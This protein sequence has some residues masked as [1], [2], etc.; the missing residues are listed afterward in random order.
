MEICAHQMTI[1]NFSFILLAR[2]MK[3]KNKC[4]K[5]KKSGPFLQPLFS[6]SYL[7]V[8]KVISE[9]NRGERKLRLS[10]ERFRCSWVTA[11]FEAWLAADQSDAETGKVTEIEEKK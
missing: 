1:F 10:A 5:K 2:P 8:M 7:A 9:L 6:I 11:A 3:K 4:K